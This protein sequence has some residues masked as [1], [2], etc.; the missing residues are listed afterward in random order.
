MMP[1]LW[2]LSDIPL[3]A[4]V[5]RDC[6]ISHLEPSPRDDWL[7][8]PF[9]GVIGSFWRSKSGYPAQMVV[10]VHMGYR[11]NVIA[12]IPLPGKPVVCVCSVVAEVGMLI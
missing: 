12:L 6:I 9:F 7:P 8:G 3:P 1:W 11:I 2:R 5:P 10:M 4:P